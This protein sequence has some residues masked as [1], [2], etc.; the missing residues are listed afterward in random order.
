MKVASILAGKI[1]LPDFNKDLKK[2]K[3]NERERDEE[4]EKEAEVERERALKRVII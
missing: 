4:E 3:K 1:S 2:K